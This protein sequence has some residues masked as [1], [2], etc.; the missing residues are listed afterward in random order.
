VVVKNELKKGDQF[1]EVMREQHARKYWKVKSAEREHSTN[2]D[3]S[4]LNSSSEGNSDF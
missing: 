2:S 3:N 1:N 4:K